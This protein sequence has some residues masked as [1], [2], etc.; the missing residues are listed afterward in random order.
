MTTGLYA[1]RFTI[2]LSDIGRIV[3]VDE[4]VPP[5]EG[6]PSASATVAEI[7]MTLPNLKVLG[8]QIGALVAKHEKKRT[9]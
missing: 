9:E 7:V 1:N 4:R 6:L 2:E 8:E 5:A 3:F